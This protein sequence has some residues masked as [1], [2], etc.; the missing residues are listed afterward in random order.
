[1]SRQVKPSKR[2]RH[3]RISNRQPLLSSGKRIPP[4]DS[5]RKLR[6]KKTLSRK[7]MKKMVMSRTRKMRKWLNCPS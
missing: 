6:K 5:K 7:K 4:Q 1:M 3:H 2:N